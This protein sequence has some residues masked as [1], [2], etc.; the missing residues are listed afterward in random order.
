MHLLRIELENFKSF[1]GEITVPFDEGFTAITG[2]NGSGKSNS[3]DAIQFVLGTRS[4]KVMR[5]DNVADLIFNGGKSGKP[6][7]HMSVTLVFAN[8]PDID[9]RRRLRIDEDEAHFTRSVRLSRKNQPV[10]SYK[11]GDRPVTA[12]EMRRTLAEAGLHG[13]GYN[14][15]LQGDVTNLA[16]MTP[17]RRRGVLEEVAGVTAY[18]KEINSA[19]NQRKRVEHDIET[20][21]LFESEQKTRLKKLEKEREQAL[22]FKAL[23]D[24]LD[25][26]KVTLGQSRYRNRIDEIQMLNEDHTKY[27]ERDAKL[28][29]STREANQ[30]LL[31]MEEELVAIRVELDGM[32]TGESKAV[33]DQ[34][35]ALEIEIE[36]SR[37]RIGDQDRASDDATIEHEEL[38]EELN[39]A[40][41]EAE[42]IQLAIDNAKAAVETANAN[43][44][45]AEA[46][47]NEARNAIESGDKHARDLNRALGKATEEVNKAHSAKAE[48]R[49]N[50][51]RAEQAAR[52]ASDRLAELEEEYENATL[53]R[54]DLELTGEDLRGEAPKQDRGELASQLTK[55][56]KQE[57]ALREDRDRADAQVREAT[58]A[59]ER[60]RTQQEARSSRPGSAVTLRS[61]AKLRESGEI[62]GILGS[63]GELTSPKDSAHESALAYALG[64]GM[65]SIVVNDD[66]V[67]ANCIKWLKT[68]GG[69]RATFLPLNK[70]SASRAQGRALMVARN[71]GVV[72]FAH[73]LL[74]YDDEI[75]TAVRFACRNT[76]IVQAMDV[77]RRNMGGVRMVTLDG[78]IVEATGAM[79]GGA[80]SKGNRPQFG[81]AGSSGAKMEKLEAAL[82]RANLYYSTV[83]AALDELR[84]N[85]NNL[86]NSIHGLDGSDH[87]VKIHEWKADVRLAQKQVDDIGKKVISARTEFE[88]A[89]SASKMAVTA[90]ANAVE[91]YEDA[92]AAR[93]A[94]AEALQNQTPDHLSQLLRS[95]QDTRTEAERTKLR[96]EVE[97]TSGE[98][99]LNV[100]LERTTNLSRSLERQNDIISKAKESIEKL[101]S[102]ISKAEGELVELKGQESQFNEELQ[103]LNSRREQLI[104]ERA[105]LRSH[106]EQ[107]ESNRESIKSRLEGLVEQIRQKEATVGVLEDELNELGIT[108]PTS[109]I[110]L[111]TVAEAEKRV[112]G[113][114]R[115]LSQLG[116]VNMLA[117]DDY[118]RTVERI[119]ALVADGKLCKD[120]HAMLV[121]LAENL[122]E[123]RKTRILAVFSHVN[124]N[125]KRAY[126][127]LQP[128]GE[129]QLL[130]ENPKNPFEGGL[131]MACIPPGKS[132]R[133]RR[134]FL[135][136]GEKS[137][138]AL[139]FIFAI[140]DYEPSP[141]YYFDEVD[142]NLDPFN[143]ERIATLCR[144]RSR[145]AQF[146]MVTLRKVSLT[147]AD[148]HIGITHAGDGCSR[149]I[150][151]FDRAAA[152]ELGEEFE[153]EKAAQEKAK[154][155]KESMTD[156]PKPENMPRVPEPMGKPQS[157][158]GL[159]ERAGVSDD[160]GESAEFVE[161]EAV[162]DDESISS[163]KERTEE[164]T[165]DISEKEAATP[166]V[167]EDTIE[168]EKT[169][170]PVITVLDEELEE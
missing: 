47:E 128:G 62:R 14:I 81:G 153:A 98:E 102:V 137:M 114:D 113:L 159:A 152:L 155:E 13:D 90:A 93:N 75:E 60:A 99:R 10:S 19:N 20:I 104:D 34:I 103:Q 56:Q 139:A 97:I 35:R 86:R 162:V 82:S 32:S 160:E 22:K 123:E 124:T 63:L 12:T 121:S 77:A 40:N 87:S 145:Q 3:G 131:E 168:I 108:I 167:E 122:E 88:K 119:A 76:L 105:S 100:M 126:E 78:S 161:A 44:D 53:E 7:R 68:N 115:R 74:D 38:Q 11:I 2:P 147:L 110:Q 17:H 107:Q 149:R 129:G 69:G 55:L 73:D 46:D 133:T 132:K 39:R 136:G 21:E 84:E 127:M 23:K 16:T 141:F 96:A 166:P 92:L 5:A 61:L 1:G 70:I 120:R 57:K 135:S 109:E 25:E 101:E 140:Q 43:L 4:T 28:R 142:Q 106:V 48:V 80:T 42:K 31:K 169:N 58:M 83:K 94:A 64:G 164:W 41:D 163:L 59:L 157:L 54:D 18:D 79:T 151:D 30:R 66:E 154:I 15:V 134:S 158:G 52:L 89:D 95:A 146:I 49:L 138:A 50:S 71:P 170:N 26:A 117:I 143:A 29:E 33:L 8:T 111:P 144:L 85:Q 67:A 156:L 125:F 118:D 27:Q 72:G 51:D 112:Q 130:L 150:A 91:L 36:T 148:H 9:G 37:D 165:E 65:N 45:K 24:E 116:D 6:A